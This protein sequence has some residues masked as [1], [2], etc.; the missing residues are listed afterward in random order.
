MTI[1]FFDSE[2]NPKIIQSQFSISTDDKGDFYITSKVNNK[3]YCVGNFKIRDF[4]SFNDIKESEHGGKL[5]I[6]IGNRTEKH[7]KS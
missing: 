6:I 2:E 3:T 5:Y 4:Q 1:I 7:E